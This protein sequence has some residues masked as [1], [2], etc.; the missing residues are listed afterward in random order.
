M[1][2]ELVVVYV[3]RVTD[4]LCSCEPVAM[5]A[6]ITPAYAAPALRMPCVACVRAQLL[7]P[8]QQHQQG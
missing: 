6:C 1:Y 3:V 5:A 8:E 7:R 4:L 2:N